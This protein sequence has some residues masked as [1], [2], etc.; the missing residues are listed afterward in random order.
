MQLFLQLPVIVPLFASIVADDKRNELILVLSWPGTF[1]YLLFV[2][3]TPLPVLISEL[4]VAGNTVRCGSTF[5]GLQLR[6]NLRGCHFVNGS[7]P[8]CLLIGPK[9]AYMAS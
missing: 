6:T 2:T 4:Y 9:I 5:L 1:C 8:S 3:W 7:Q